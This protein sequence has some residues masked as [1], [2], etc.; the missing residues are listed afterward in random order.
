MYHTLYPIHISNECVVE[1]VW[2]SRETETTLVPKIHDPQRDVEAHPAQGKQKS[3][4]NSRAS[5]RPK[6]ATCQPKQYETTN[7]PTTNKTDT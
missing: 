3:R 4:S 6:D 2:L 7:N 5:T 1:S